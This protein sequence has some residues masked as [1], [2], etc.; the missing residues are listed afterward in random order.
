MV[1]ASDTLSTVTWQYDHASRVKTQIVTQKTGESTTVDFRIDNTFDTLSNR[2]SFSTQLGSQSLRPV[3][4]TRTDDNLRLINSITDDV[5]LVANYTYNS[6]GRVATK[7]YDAPGSVRQLTYDNF[8]R[9]TQITCTQ[10]VAGD[11][12]EFEYAFNKVGFRLYEYRE[13]LNKG[14]AYLYDKAYRIIHSKYD[15]DDF[16]KLQAYGNGGD[17]GG[18][19]SGDYLNPYSYKSY[20]LDGEGNREVTEKDGLTSNPKRISHFALRSSLKRT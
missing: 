13:H 9:L 3:S 17:F 20:A 18:I 5:E 7:T 8:T 10:S 2:M 15:V 16:T 1:T 19:V 4:F 14:D 11:L 6:D 12:A